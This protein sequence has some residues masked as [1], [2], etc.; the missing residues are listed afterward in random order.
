VPLHL[1]LERDYP[2]GP[3]RVPPDVVRAMGVVP[4]PLR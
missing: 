2:G 1:G 3:L 4:E